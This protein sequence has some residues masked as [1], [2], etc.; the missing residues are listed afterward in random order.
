MLPLDGVE[1]YGQICPKKLRVLSLAEAWQDAL[2]D[3][4]PL[5][6]PSQI[7]RTGQRYWYVHGRHRGC[8]LHAMLVGKD[9]SGGPADVADVA[10]GFATRLG[11]T[12]TGMA[13]TLKM[14]H[15][16]TS[17]SWVDIIVALQQCHSE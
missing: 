15:A 2:E 4:F 5:F 8:A 11:V 13:R 14:Q 17:V 10:D 16:T 7:E 3:K 12:S 1:S 6:L 9:G